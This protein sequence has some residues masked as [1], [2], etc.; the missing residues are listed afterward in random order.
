MS[1]YRSFN[2]S[3]YR[4]RFGGF[5]FFP[6]VIKN[7]ILI[8]VAVFV[9]QLVFESGLT[10]GGRP[11]YY[12]FAETFFLYPLGDGFLPWQLVTYMFLHGNFTHILFNMLMLW[13]FGME[14]ENTWGSKKFLIFYFASGIVA[15]LANL[16]IAPMFSTPGATIGASGGVYGVLTAFALMFPN[17]YIYL[18]FFVPIRAKYLITF[19]FFIE[20]YNGIAGTMDGIAHIAHL[21]GAV[22]GAIW[23]LLDRNGS[24]DRMLS[25]V[26]RRRAVDSAP[27]WDNSPREAKFFDFT[28]GRE[29]AKKSDP[30]FDKSQKMID[31]ILDKI[32]VS[33]YSS[34]TEEEKRILLDASKRIHPDKDHH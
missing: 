11:I 8:N 29:E 34:L 1:A 5:S 9:L 2:N 19:L 16:F 23:V 30:E 7:V 20:V 6:P 21:G 17:R 27:G 3:D 26:G 10:F 32:S 33:G 13:M 25:S 14:L 4:P 28:P 22:V 18:W 15:G 31:D 24:I 12:W